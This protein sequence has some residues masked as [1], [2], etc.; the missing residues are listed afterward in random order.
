V[1]EFVEECRRE[2]RRLRVPDPVANEMAADLEAD[3]E[4]AEAEGVSPEEVLG[5]AAFD[6]RTFAASWA[7]ARGVIRP[8]PAQPDVLPRRSRLPVAIAAFAL[9]AIVGALLAIVA[10]HA[11]AGQVAVASPVGPPKLRAVP[12][13]SGID[14]RSVG[15]LLLLVG[16][17]G[18]ALSTVF[19]LGAG[20]G[21]WSR[22]R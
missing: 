7:A 15:F 8:A 13:G 2:W 10:S 20:P 3:L 6:P 9:V 17:V 22:F 21:R 1:N 16:V 14:V 18:S 19:W 11:L 5:S 4:E 12:G